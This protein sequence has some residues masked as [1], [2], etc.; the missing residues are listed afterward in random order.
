[1]KLLIFSIL[2]KIVFLRFQK[3][4]SGIIPKSPFTEIKNITDPNIIKGISFVAD[5]YCPVVNFG[6]D[7]AKLSLERLRATGANW[8]AIIV[9]EYLRNRDDTEINPCYPY[10]L[11][12]TPNDYYTFKTETL[13]DLTTIINYA[14][15]IGLQVLLKP[16]LDFVDEDTSVWRGD[17]K[18]HKEG[19]WRKFFK[20]YETF[21][22]K[23]A[24]LAKDLN[25]EM[26]SIGCETQGITHRT[27]NWNKIIDLVHDVYPGPLTYSANHSGEEVRIEWWGHKWINYIGVDAYYITG[28][29]KHDHSEN[30]EQNYHNTLKSLKK[31]SET[32]DKPI[33]IAEIGFCSGSCHIRD[34]EKRVA[35]ANDIH[36]Q[37]NHYAKFMEIF[38]NQ[39]FIK[40]I[41]WWA[42]NSDPYYGGNEDVCISP[43]YKEAEIVLNRFYGGSNNTP[44]SILR[45]RGV[46]AKCKCTI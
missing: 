10:C 12:K 16:H 8:V 23:Y 27:N 18:Y 3:E 34:R 24:N 38:M 46:K 25:V 7:L 36:R 33:I 9:T 40:G 26:F 30:M 31:L 41:F 28:T 1:M 15:E 35:D 4:S 14:K 32:Y 39:S 13:L 44:K 29:E 45:P 37:R 21:I 19:D 11:P 42:W 5:K 6:D 22:L 17:I 2:T 43:Q 20:S